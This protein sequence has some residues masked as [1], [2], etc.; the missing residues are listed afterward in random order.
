MT[1]LGLNTVS[2]KIAFTARGLA[3]TPT[4]KR[5]LCVNTERHNGFHHESSVMNANSDQR[6]L[7]RRQH[8]SRNRAPGFDAGSVDFAIVVAISL[9]WNISHA[10]TGSAGEGFVYTLRTEILAA[11]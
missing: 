6:M 5:D 3:D 2:D 10:H 11:R 9:G 8:E 4:F 7:R 1:G